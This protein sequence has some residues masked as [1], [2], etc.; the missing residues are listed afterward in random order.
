MIYIV[1]GI[2]IVGVE[3]YGLVADPL[4]FTFIPRILREALPPVLALV[5][6][7]GSNLHSAAEMLT[8][9]LLFLMFNPELV[10]DAVPVRLATMAVAILLMWTGGRTSGEQIQV[11]QRFGPSIAGVIAMLVLGLL[12]VALARSAAVSV[13]F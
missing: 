13:S 10:G 9:A 7:R 3:G 5:A 8:A 2:L 4:T 6:L 12:L 11:H 1:I